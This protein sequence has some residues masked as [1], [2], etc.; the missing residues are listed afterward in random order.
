MLQDGT[1][2]CW[3]SALQREVVAA[4]CP[5]CRAPP[6]G[7]QAGEGLWPGECGGAATLILR[8]AQAAGDETGRSPVGCAAVGMGFG[9]RACMCRRSALS[10]PPPR[11]EG[12]PASFIGACKAL[13]LRLESSR[14]PPSAFLNAREPSGRAGLLHF[15]APRSGQP[16]ANRV[17]YTSRSATHATQP[18]PRSPCL[19]VGFA[20]PSLPASTPQRP[21][22]RSEGRGPERGPGKRCC[23]CR[24]SGCCCAALCFGTPPPPPP[25]PPP[26][27]RPPAPRR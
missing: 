2:G 7:G 26:T 12:V 4:T 10:A 17:Y 16:L 8:C 6:A 13:W 18:R 23:C 21:E 22:P 3:S 19:Q 15:R 5:A 1:C 20:P 24:R 25:P 11:H 27:P 9:Q 14:G